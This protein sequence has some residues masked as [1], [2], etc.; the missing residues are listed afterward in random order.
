MMEMKYLQMVIDETLRLY[1][2]VVHLVRQAEKD[3]RI[4]KTELVIPKGKRIFIPIHAIHHDPEYYP[5]PDKFIPE[6]F[7]DDNKNTR[8]PMTHLPFGNGPRN[9]LGL[10]F[11][12]MQTKISIIQLLM[13]FKF[14]PSSQTPIPMVLHPS[15]FVVSSRDVIHLKVEQMVTRERNLTQCLKLEAVCTDLSEKAK[16][17]K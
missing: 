9:C 5:E 6:R 14:S 11:G 13:N 8:H 12:L 4:P 16:Q 17:M 10:R 7:S 2:P 3:Y 15:A 1:G